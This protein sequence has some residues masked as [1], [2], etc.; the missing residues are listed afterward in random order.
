[1]PL[2]SAALALLIAPRNGPPFPPLSKVHE[3]GFPLVK[4]CGAGGS[5]VG[6]CIDPNDASGTTIGTSGD[7]CCGT[8]GL[9][10]AGIGAGRATGPA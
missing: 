6:G 8:K 9:D 1:M 5:D 7:D 2:L 3:S 10:V 4:T